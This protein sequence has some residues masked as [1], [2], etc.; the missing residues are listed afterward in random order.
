MRY[1]CLF[2]LPLFFLCLFFFFFSPKTLIEILHRLRRNDE[3]FFFKKK[4]V[5]NNK[6]Q[7]QRVGYLNFDVEEFGSF[8]IDGTK[9]IDVVKKR[10]RFWDA[11]AHTFRMYEKKCTKKTTCQQHISVFNNFRSNHCRHNYNSNIIIVFFHTVFFLKKKRNT[12]TTTHNHTHTNQVPGEGIGSPVALAIA[13]WTATN[14]STL[15]LP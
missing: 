7:Q 8:W 2:F 12:H 11:R 15:S 10:S 1:L 3:T 5:P 14:L 4:D 13:C 6:Q 9:R